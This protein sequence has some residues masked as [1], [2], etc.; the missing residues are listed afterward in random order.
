LDG[1][2]AYLRRVVVDDALG[3]CAELER[4]MASLVAS[5][6]CEWTAV[7]RDP[8]RRKAFRECVTGGGAAIR[9]PFVPARGQSR[10]ADGPSPAPAAPLREAGDPA[11]GARLAAVDDVPRD[12][13][14][15][16]AHGDTPIAVFH[17]ASRGTWYATQAICPHRKD[18]VLGRGLL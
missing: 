17:F 12:G 13:G 1:G 18:A 7:V 11:E 15:T 4:D 5:Y 3:I 14:I 10:P 8:E 16:V 9:L 6:R 2:I